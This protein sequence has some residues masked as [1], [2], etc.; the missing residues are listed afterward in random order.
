[1]FPWQTLF[2]YS[3]RG[4]L[5]ARGSTHLQAESTKV[6]VIFEEASLRGDLNIFQIDLLHYCPI[7]PTGHPLGQQF[8]LFEFKWA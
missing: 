5:E 8:G 2:D 3:R 1:M 4:L 7:S 6:T